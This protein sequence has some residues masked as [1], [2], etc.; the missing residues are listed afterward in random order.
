LSEYAI[1]IT[2]LFYDMTMRCRQQNQVARILRH[3]IFSFGMVAELKGAI[4]CPE[5]RATAF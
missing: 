3:S 2:A 5:K 1:A 4:S